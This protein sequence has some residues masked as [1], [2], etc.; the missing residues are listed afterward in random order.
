MEAGVKVLHA[1]ATEAGIDMGALLEI[2]RPR[3]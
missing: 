1:P 3:G 2:L